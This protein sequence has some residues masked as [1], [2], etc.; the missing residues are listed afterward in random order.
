MTDNESHHRSFKN[1]NFLFLVAF[2]NLHFKHRKWLLMCRPHLGLTVPENL[3]LSP[4]PSPYSLC[5]SW[6]TLSGPRKAVLPRLGWCL[7]RCAHYIFQVFGYLPRAEIVLSFHFFDLQKLCVTFHAQLHYYLN[8]EAFSSCKQLP[9]SP[10]SFISINT[11]YFCC[12]I[13]TSLFSTEFL[14]HVLIPHEV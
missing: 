2:E 13:S 5:H 8:F 10:L 12:F 7:C 11:H 4:L 6:P 9:L 1:Y 14:T 3:P